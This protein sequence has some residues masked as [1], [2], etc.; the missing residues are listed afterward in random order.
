MA[1]PSHKFFL[2]S[3]DI[4]R[5]GNDAAPELLVAPVI[6]SQG[7]L[8]SYGLPTAC[9]RLCDAGQ[10]EL[11]IY[12]SGPGEPDRASD[13]RRVPTRPGRNGVAGRGLHGGSTTGFSHAG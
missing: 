11:E 10:Q 3:S 6:K 7:A 9:K 4:E 5:L 2:F 8:H 1:A 13:A 12:P